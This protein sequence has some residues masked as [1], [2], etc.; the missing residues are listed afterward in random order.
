MILKDRIA[1]VTGAGSGIGRAG[2]LIMAREGAHVIIADLD[3]KNAAE[4]VSQI[5]AAGGS[6][7]SLVVDV[8][9]DKALEAGIAAVASRHGRIDILHNHAGAQ[10]A[11]DLEQ[12]AVDG[13]DRSWSLNVRAHFM[14]SRFV[15]PL[16]KK[17]GKGVILNT[18]SSSG[19]L[20]D[21]EMI[22]YTTTKHAVIA[23]TRQMAGDYAKFGIRVNALCPGWVDTPFNEPF[24]AQMGGRNAIES[25]I[26]AQVPLGRWADVSEIA[27][28]ILFLVSDR[29][30]YMTGQ[31]LIVD[32]GETVV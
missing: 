3:L 12:V 30:S 28:P 23:M 11:G 17:A 14:A 27:E 5:T 13:F 10:V 32:G 15:M 29:S 22:A 16:M 25:Y 31:I 20:Y 19:V 24:I 9:D 1:I 2:A 4:S 8:T 6:A 21:R 26:S 7:E 18:S